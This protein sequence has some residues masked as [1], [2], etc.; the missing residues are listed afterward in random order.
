MQIQSNNNNFK[1]KGKYTLNNYKGCLKGGAIG[2]ALGWPVEFLQISN[3]KKQ[4]GQKGIEDLFIKTN[5][6]AEITDDT[7][8]T[9]FT[10]DGI[11][12]SLR[13]TLNLNKIPNM[14]T[15]FDSYKLWLNTQRYITAIPKNKGWISELKDL[16]AMRAPGSTC[17][18]SL[19][20]N[21]PGSIEKP[22][23]NS[24]GCGGVMRV[25]PVGLMYKDNEELAFEIGARCAALT[26]G[27]PQ[28]YLSAGFLSCMIAHIIN[29]NNIHNAVD[30][31]IKYLK[32]YPNHESTLNLINKAKE[33]ANSNIEPINAIEELGQGWEGHEAIAI[34]IYSSLKEPNNFEKALKIAVNHSGDSDST[35]AIT[36]N[37][38][39]AHLGLDAIPNKWNE[40]TELSKELEQLSKDLYKPFEIENIEKR[41]P[42]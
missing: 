4:Y 26:H 33:L 38:I 29:G 35:G 17:I 7:Q 12:K 28:A 27:N 21:I 2:D 14:N 6:K 11:I 16:Y 1:F 13:Q 37:I 5:K 34:S 8:M 24:S 22:I 40:K 41:Y 32:K 30:S 31:T 3:I 9:M 18:S 39:G 19:K 20:R 15:I 36:G 23:N 25:A 42:I 10:A